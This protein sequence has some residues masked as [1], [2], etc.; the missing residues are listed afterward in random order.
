MNWLIDKSK[1]YKNNVDFSFEFDCNSQ[2]VIYL[3]TC[4][5]CWKQYVG[6]TITLFR[7][8]FSK[9]ISVM[10]LYAQGTQGMI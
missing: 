3:I 6:S 9:Y 7:R 2:R 4:K 1:T 8:W 5:V 10:K